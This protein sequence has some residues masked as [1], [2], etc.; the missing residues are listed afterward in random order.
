MSAEHLTLAPDGRPLLGQTV[1]LDLLDLATDAE[2][3]F[4]ALDHDEVWAAGYAVG[5]ERPRTVVAFRDDILPRHPGLTTYTVRLVATGEIVGTTS[6][7]DV[8]T[9]QEQCHL[10]WTAYTPHVWRTKVNPECKYL[11]LRHCF[12]DLG[13]GRVKI[14]TDNVNTRSQAAIAKLGATKEGVLRRHRR[15]AD[16]SFRDTVVFSVLVDEWP[17]VKAGLEQRLGTSA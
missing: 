1:R 4:H 16:G 12:E 17:R 8:L 5:K 13:M 15:R 10:G 2:P 9:E 11:L 6:I 7:G 14:Q 3:L